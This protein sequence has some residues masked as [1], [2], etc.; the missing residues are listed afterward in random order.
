VVFTTGSSLLTTL[1]SIWF[2][3]GLRW[4]TTGALV[5]SLIAP[6]VASAGATFLLLRSA[7]VRFRPALMKAGFLFGIPLVPASI[8]GWILRL[9]D[10]L[11][12]QPYVSLADIGVYSLGYQIGDAISLLGVTIN[13]AWSPFY[14][15]TFQ[16]HRQKAPAMLAPIIT[17]FALVVIAV[18][19]AIAALSPEIIHLLAKPNYYMAY[20]V[21]PWVA[22]GAAMRVLN[23]IPRQGIM[24]AKKTYWEPLLSIIGGG[25]NIGLN[26]LLLPRVGYI[27]A[28]W[29]TLIGYTLM[30]ILAL[31]ISQKVHPIVY[32]YK[33]LAILGASALIIFFIS[34]RISLESVGLS[35]AVK[36]GLLGLYP[37][38]LWLL[39]FVSERERKALHKF[40]AGLRAAPRPSN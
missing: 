4:A 29:T 27:A 36:T 24:Y 12:M 18:A 26:L 6:A 10:R 25:V 35:L 3:A 30:T 9:S 32:E 39:G 21:V 13:S 31:I 34:Q 19:L 28:A 37:V 40:Y 2:V 20:G 17:Y 38:L 8:F 5:A 22:A 11:V 1:I 23:W 15:R 16:E 14:Y 33:R 7:T